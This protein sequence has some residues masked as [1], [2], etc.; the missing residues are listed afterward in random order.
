MWSD[1]AFFLSTRLNKDRIRGHS[2]VLV[3][4][5]LEPSIKKLSKFN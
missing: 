4:K 2:A 1:F 3:R 5:W